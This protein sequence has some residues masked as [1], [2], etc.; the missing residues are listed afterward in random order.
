MAR[1]VRAK[2]R[3]FGTMEQLVVCTSNAGKLTEFR[4]LLPDGLDLLTLVDVGITDEL[5]ETGTTL[6]QN[7]LQ[8]AREAHRRCGLPCVADDTGLEVDALQGAPG[9]RSARYAG[10][11]RSSEANMRLLIDRMHGRQQRTA[12]FRTVLA[13]VDDHGEHLVE[14]TVEGSI[15]LTPR[16]SGGF[17][18]DPVFLPVGSDRTF[19]EMS[20]AEK[21]SLSHRARA[22]QQF[23][24]LLKQ[25]RT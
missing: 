9:V 16:G 1:G 12:R 18:Y 22:V 19:A 7:A 25:H 15:A 11:A 6:A 10:E 3:S 21:N 5:A 14:G 4:S 23:V 2:V 17:G 24:D 20:A 8:K 13:L